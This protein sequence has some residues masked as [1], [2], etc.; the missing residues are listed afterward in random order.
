MTVPG[1]LPTM[2]IPSKF[3]NPMAD[4]LPL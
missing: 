3:K 4:G 1:V 2:P